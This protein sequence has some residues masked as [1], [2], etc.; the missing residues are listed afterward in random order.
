[1]SSTISRDTNQIFISVIVP[2]HNEQD[3]VKKLLE[4]IVLVSP[5]SGI[6]EIIFVDDCSND[7]T[8]K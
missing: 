7:E 1:M 5:Q 6:C 2:V 4:E 3:N 8:A